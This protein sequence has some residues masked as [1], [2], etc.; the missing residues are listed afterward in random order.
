MTIQTNK[1]VSIYVDR[2]LFALQCNDANAQRIADDTINFNVPFPK[3]VIRGSI[4]QGIS[5]GRLAIVSG[6]DGLVLNYQIS[7]LPIRMLAIGFIAFGLI[8]PVYLFFTTNTIDEF[9]MFLLMPVIGLIMAAFAY[10]AGMFLVAWQIH[11]FLLKSLKP[12]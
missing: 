3:Y 8:L 2:L 6:A 10:F 12:K 4:F 7:I 1:P 5:F 9:A 11:T